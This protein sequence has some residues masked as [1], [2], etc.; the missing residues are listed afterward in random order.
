MKQCSVLNFNTPENYI[1]NGLWFGPENA[2]CGFIFLHGLSASAF[3]LHDTLIPLI[4]NST[5]AL[6]FS[7]RGHDKIA[8]VKKYKNIND[9]ETVLAGEA[10]EVFTEC[11]D[12]I[13]GA[14]N[15]LKEK[16][17]KEIYLVGHST[18]CQ[19]S[20]YYLGQNNNQENIKGVVLLCPISDYSSAVATEN[21][22]KLKKAVDFA[23]KQVKDGKPHALLPE[24]ISEDLLDAQ[25]FLSLN[26]PDSE[27]EIFTYSQ[28]GKIPETLL[29][30]EIPILVIL[31]E[32]DEYGDR[33][34]SEIGDW[35]SKV[36]KSKK[37]GVKIIKKAPH[38]LL[39]KEYQVA[40]QIK[41]WI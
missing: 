35:F 23:K 1:L 3:V 36:S 15:L 4:D 34:A 13:Q 24:E 41:E 12:D 40:Q 33:P 11:V 28:P 16:G 29:N 17:V 6:F 14:I 7:N 37:L 38:N 27:E 9:Y 31:A 5:M 21:P 39:G 18:G 26:T 30:V 25:R 2:E 10:H 32:D 22:D 8:K 20:I 19:K